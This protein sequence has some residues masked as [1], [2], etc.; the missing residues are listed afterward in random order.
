MS[1]A[2]LDQIDPDRP[3]SWQGVNF[4]TLDLDW[5]S[6]EALELT[7]SLLEQA[8]VPA[9][10]FV[11]HATPVLERMRAQG[12]EL[13]IHPNFDRWLWGQDAANGGGGDEILDRLVQLV[14]EARSWRSHCLTQSTTLQRQLAQRGFSHS[15]NTFL[16]WGLGMQ[17]RP[18]RFPDCL[19]EAPI[20]WE[21]DF[22]LAAPDRLG[23]AHQL[24]DWGGLRVWNFHPVHLY[25]NTRD[26]SH[27]QAYK[28]GRTNQPQTGRGARWQLERLLG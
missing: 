25:L 7:C 14:P 12:W 8:A 10:L 23:D 9:T 22:W 5:A 26:W 21:D 27:Y 18:F 19:V 4:L 16:E 15:S 24:L 1:W 2:R 11:T 6:H 28:E 20:A 13:G 17:N 3:E